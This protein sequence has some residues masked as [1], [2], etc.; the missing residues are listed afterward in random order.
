MVN[1]GGMSDFQLTADRT[2]PLWQS[3]VILLGGCNVPAHDEEHDVENS[4]LL[5]YFADAW[6]STQD[7]GKD[8]GEGMRIGGTG[9]VEER[10]DGR[11]GRADERC[12]RGS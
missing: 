7:I 3:L 8:F 4:D 9:W 12:S 5:W 10:G 11:V 2:R 1:P 6:K